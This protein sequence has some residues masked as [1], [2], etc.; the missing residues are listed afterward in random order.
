MTRVN[1]K[2]DRCHESI[3]SFQ[4]PLRAS[5]L[6]I[7]NDFPWHFQLQKLIVNIFIPRPH[8]PRE[9]ST[10]TCPRRRSAFHPKAFGVL[11]LWHFLAVN[12]SSFLCQSI[13]LVVSQGFSRV[14]VG[15]TSCFPHHLLPEHFLMSLGPTAR[16]AWPFFSRCLSRTLNLLVA[17]SEKFFSLP[18]RCVSVMDPKFN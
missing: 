3:V 8:A 4:S 10:F 2:V 5:K 12:K 1:W 15:T 9:S 6:H 18:R 14:A 13:R 7:I 11:M 17:E 16:Y